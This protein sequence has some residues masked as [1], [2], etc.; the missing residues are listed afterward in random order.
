M[1]P[2][3]IG[4]RRK[5]HVSIHLSLVLTMSNLCRECS[6]C[7]PSE[8]EGKFQLALLIVGGFPWVIN[9]CCVS[10]LHRVVGLTAV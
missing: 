3:A 10:P 1:G 8:V 7:I 2:M 4:L 6:V 5:V 9:V